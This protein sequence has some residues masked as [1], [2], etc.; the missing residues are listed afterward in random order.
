MI[1][2]EPILSETGVQQGD[3]LGPVLF[4][5]AAEEIARS[6]RSPINN[7]Y[8]DDDT[9]S[10]TVE[11]VC[12]DRRWIIP[13]L[14]DIGLEVNPTKSE[15]SN[16]SC[17]N[18]QSVLLAIESALPKVTVTERLSTMSSRLESIEANP[19]FFLLRNCPSMPRLLLSLEALRA[20]DC[21]QTLR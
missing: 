5:L 6:V 4:A 16:V 20:T 2:N 11:G 19:A 9:I 14:S 15:V 12:E 10:G 13:M 18:F 1:G 17:D 3:P 8:L 21:T 7:W